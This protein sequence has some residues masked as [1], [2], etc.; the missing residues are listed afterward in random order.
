M[1]VAE[2][3]SYKEYGLNRLWQDYPWAYC[4]LVK[5]P[6]ISEGGDDQYY[7]EPLIL[8]YLG[9]MQFPDEAAAIRIVQLPFLDTVEWG[10]ASVME[11]LTDISA[12]NPDGFAQLL[13]RKSLTAPDDPPVQILY[14]EARDA[15]AAAALANQEWVKDGIYYREN[16]TLTYLQESAMTS[17]RFFD[18]LIEGNRSWIPLQTSLDESS[19]YG[20]VKWSHFDEDTV[21]QLADMPFMDTIEITDHEAIYR[22]YELAS[23]NPEAV[24]RILSQPLFDDGIT[25]E[26]AIHLILFYLDETLPEAAAAIR[27]LPWVQDGIAY[28]PH[29]PSLGS[30]NVIRDVEGDEV[31]NL[32]QLAM[33]SPEVLIELT[34]KSWMRDNINDREGWAITTFDVLASFDPQAA[35]RVLK[36]PMLAQNYDGEASRALRSIE[37][38]RW[39][40]RE[41]FDRV[42]EE[43]EAAAES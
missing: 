38:A 3:D 18:Y 30:V 36:L 13:S 40:S 19:L 10:D 43:L 23:S 5:R 20:L 9:M 7:V 21:L 27:G 37:N 16:A 33:R 28:V 35:L 31:V 39:E 11:F 4:E 25:D 42:L 32:V 1:K 41:A 24:Q 22:L 14:L 26:E 17:K 34:T 6:W 12:S 15:S 2:L 8:R 29:Q